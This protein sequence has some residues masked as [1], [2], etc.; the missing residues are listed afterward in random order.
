MDLTI[1]SIQK[2]IAILLN[3]PTSSGKSLISYFFQKMVDPPF[4]HIGIDTMIALMPERLN[5]WTGQQVEDGF[6]WKESVDEQ[7]EPMAAIQM[8]PYAVKISETYLQV[9]KTLMANGHHVIIDEVAFGPKSL[10]KWHQVLCAY[11]LY[12]VGVY[13]DLAV[14]QKREQQRQDRKVGSAKHQFLNVH[15]D[16]SYDLTVN[17]TDSNPES[18]VEK[19]VQ[20][21][22][23]L[24]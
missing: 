8:G 10:E 20:H 23:K 12:T 3:G 2:P 16:V 9:V 7:N 22:N 11:Q 18:C 24:S 15:K 14:L 1:Q 21:I 17:T 5:D 13:C 19:I 6:W 4:L